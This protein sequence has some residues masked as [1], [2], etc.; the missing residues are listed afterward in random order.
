MCLNSKD[1]V[2]LVRLRPLWRTWRTPRVRYFTCS[3]WTACGLCR[4]RQAAREVHC[5]GRTGGA[6]AMV[7]LTRIMDDAERGEGD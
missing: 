4:D 6:E 7:H 5:R 1:R 3:G 2:L